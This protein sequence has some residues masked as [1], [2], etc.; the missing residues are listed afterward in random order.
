M[1]RNGQC[2]QQTNGVYDFV[3]H[4]QTG[5]EPERVTKN[6]ALSWKWRREVESGGE[7]VFHGKWKTNVD[8]SSGDKI[9]DCNLEE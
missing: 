7:G 4:S 1:D 8:K 2:L 3:I 6:T 9:R 5:K